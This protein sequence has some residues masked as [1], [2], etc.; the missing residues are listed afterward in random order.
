VTW[1]FKSICQWLT[2]TKASC[3]TTWDFCFSFNIVWLTELDRLFQLAFPVHIIG[4]GGVLRLASPT[5]QGDNWAN[6]A[7]YNTK[8]ALYSAS[9][10]TDRHSILAGW[11][12]ELMISNIIC[13]HH[14]THKSRIVTVQFWSR[15]ILLL[16]PNQLMIQAD[17]PIFADWSTPKI[18]K[19]WRAIR[20]F[21]APSDEQDFTV[22]AFV[23]S[24][25]VYCR[26]SI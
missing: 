26:R 1:R 12:T 21:P 25:W 6:K 17:G 20:Q 8:G 9:R 2:A 3:E 22:T 13:E 4:D 16:N 15:K 7:L 10:W 24:W 11:R 14:F 19:P 5:R 23:N 18:S